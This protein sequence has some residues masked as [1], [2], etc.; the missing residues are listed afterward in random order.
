MNWQRFSAIGLL[1]LAT[2]ALCL[3]QAARAGGTYRSP[4]SVR[5]TP[6]VPDAP[7]KTSYFLPPGAP[8]GRTYSWY[9]PPAGYQVIMAGTPTEPSYVTLVGPDGK[10]RTV[11]L[12]GPIVMRP[13]SYVVRAG[14][15]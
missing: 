1:T 14:T 6:S 13:T 15:R 11:R 4:P 10:S 9:A 12:E 8:V 7:W 2:M 3:S 5:S